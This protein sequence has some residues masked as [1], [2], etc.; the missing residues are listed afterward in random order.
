MNIRPLKIMAIVISLFFLSSCAV[1]VRDDDFHHRH[2]GY[3]RWHSSL[4]P[5]GQ[6]TA[7]VTAQNNGG[8]GAHEQ[9]IR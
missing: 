9:V 7:Q 3:G 4:Q 2:H 5:S 6:S 8:S 1:W